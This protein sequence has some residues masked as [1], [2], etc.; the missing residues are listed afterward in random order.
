MVRCE[1]CGSDRLITRAGRVICENC[2]MSFDKEEIRRQYMHSSN[3]K[4][5]STSKQRR[6]IQTKT[7]LFLNETDRP[8][9]L[10]VGNIYRY[11]DLEPWTIYEIKAPYGRCVFQTLR[12]GSSKPAEC[13][14]NVDVIRSLVLHYSIGLLAPPTILTASS[15]KEADLTAMIN[16]HNSSW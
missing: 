12:E 6:P 16:R 1:Y 3:S 7:L 9:V 11:T 14:A 5:T 13:S 8:C 15:K 10:Y 2:G 4:S